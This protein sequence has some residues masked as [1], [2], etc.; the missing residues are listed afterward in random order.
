MR[1]GDQSVGGRLSNDKTEEIRDCPGRRETS[2]TFYSH[3]LFSDMMSSLVGDCSREIQM[4]NVLCVSMY[5]GGKPQPLSSM[6]RYHRY[7]PVVGTW[8]HMRGLSLIDITDY[9]LA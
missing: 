9:L 6:L 1:L 5:I 4:S 2:L 7:I 8:P 3:L